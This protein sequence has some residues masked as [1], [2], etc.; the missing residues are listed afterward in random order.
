MTFPAAVT[1]GHPRMG[2]DGEKKSCSAQ[3]F[4][5]LKQ[6]GFKPNPHPQVEMGRV[7]FPHEREQ[8]DVRGG[9]FKFK[10][11][12]GKKKTLFSP[13]SPLDLPLSRRRRNRGPRAEGQAKHKT[14]YR[15]EV[16]PS[17]IY[18]WRR[19]NH[20]SIYGPLT[21]EGMGEKKSH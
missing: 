21:V 13:L 2:E 10:K 5:P 8:F 17:N 12:G 18:Y 19:M 4:P 7:P 11:I 6:R 15:L 20:F 1:L 9:I 3:S 16:H 14:G